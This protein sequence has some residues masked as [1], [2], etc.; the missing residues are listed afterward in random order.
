MQKNRSEGESES[1]KR[2]GGNRKGRE[3]KQ[4]SGEKR[5]KVRV[6]KGWEKVI[7]KV[8]KW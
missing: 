2:G 3:N 8:G 5:E 7:E 6:R 1:V 4:E